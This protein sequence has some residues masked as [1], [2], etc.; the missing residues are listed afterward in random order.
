MEVSIETNQ[1]L[2]TGGCSLIRHSVSRQFTCLVLSDKW[3]V[4]RVQLSDSIFVR[5]SVVRQFVLFDHN[6]QGTGYN[7]SNLKIILKKSE[8]I[9][10]KILQFMI[11]A[12]H[13]S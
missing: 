9:R 13:I 11:C 6:W 10:K 2:N 1:M 12:T 4:G 7:Y 5:Q 8:R 3:T